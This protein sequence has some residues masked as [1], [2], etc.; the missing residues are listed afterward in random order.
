MNTFSFYLL[1]SVLSTLILILIYFLTVRRKSVEFPAIFLWKRIQKARF[2]R[3]LLKRFYRERLFYLHLS[4]LTLLLSTL[5]LFS[6]GK[7]I[8]GNGVKKVIFII[9]TSASMKAMENGKSRFDLVRERVLSLL[10]DFQRTEAMII[11]AGNPVRTALPFTRDRSAIENTIKGLEPEDTR[12]NFQEAILRTKVYMRE[13]VPIYILSDGASKDFQNLISQNPDLFFISV[14]KGYE[15]AGI[16]DVKLYKDNSE[17]TVFVKNF[18]DNLIHTTVDLLINGKIIDAQRIEIPAEGERTL[19]FKQ[20]HLVPGSIE[21]KIDYPDP[22][23]YDNYRYA[24]QSFS[25]VRSVL[26]VTRGN[27]FLEHILKQV[28]NYY[29]TDMNPEKYEAELLENNGIDFDI[30]IYENYTPSSQVSSASIVYINPD[31]STEEVSLVGGYIKSRSLNI[32]R[33][34]PVMHYTDFSDIQI[35]KAQRVKSF[36]GFTLL[37]SSESPLIIASEQGGKKRVVFSFDLKESNFPLSINFPIF[38]TNLLSWFQSDTENHYAY[39]LISGDTFIMN[40]PE[41]FKTAQKAMVQ[42]PDGKVWKIDIKEGVLVFPYT[43]QAGIYKVIFENGGLDFAVNID[44][45]ES[46]IRPLEYKS[47]SM[48]NKKGLQLTFHLLSIELWKVLGVLAVVILF[49][50]ERLRK[51]RHRI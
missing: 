7:T 19:T 48:E 27:Y 1:F 43:K 39:N 30:V 9:D 15:N 33:E 50:E 20:V 38:F 12:D 29:L 34:H 47:H 32:L 8:T 49:H 24:I 31:K 22:F 14:G 10:D 21:V 36:R 25:E 28:D 44:S 2:E 46:E 18:H 41:R 37:G 5:I 6:L 4:I 3:P 40:L 17:V 13:G 42:S 51:D 11:T 26:L 23:S 45:S 16:L 35:P